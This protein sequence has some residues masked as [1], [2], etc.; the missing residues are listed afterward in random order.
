MDA[1][2]ADET[3]LWRTINTLV[4]V[5]F[6]AGLVIALYAG[7]NY[8]PGVSPVTDVQAQKWL[9]LRDVPRP[10]DW[11]PLVLPRRQC[12]VEWEPCYDYFRSEFQAV[13]GQMAVYV[14]RFVGTVR[15]ILNG[16]P[17]EDYGRLEQPVDIHFVPRM[18]RLPAPLLR[19]GSNQLDF[20]LT[21]EPRRFHL[22]GHFYIGLEEDLRGPFAV[23]DYLSNTLPML[24]IGIYLM[25]GLLSLIVFWLGGRDPIFGWFV[26]ITL[27]AGLRSY[28]FLWTDIESSVF[29]ELI[30]FAGSF[31]SLAVILAFSRQITGP[32]ADRRDWWLLAAVLLWAVAVYGSSVLDPKT[33]GQLG[34]QSLRI[35][36]ILFGAATMVQLYRYFR[37]GW[38]LVKM[39]SFVLFVTAFLFVLH[40]VAVTLSGNFLLAQLSNLSPLLVVLAF[41]LIA[42][43]RFSHALNRANSYNRELADEIDSARA[44]MA[45]AY[46]ELSAAKEEALILS[47]R[48]RIMREVHDGVGGKLAGMLYM[49]RRD[50]LSE[51]DFRE[52]ATHLEESLIDLR[53]IID[54]I[55]SD[56]VLNLG[57]TLRNF[58]SRV[59]P[60][61]EQHGI[62]VHIAAREADLNLDVSASWVLSVIRVLQEATS[63]V[64]RHADASRIAVTIEVDQGQLNLSIVDDGHGYAGAPTGRGIG[65]MTE[66]CREI[67]GN[68]RIQSNSAGTKVYASLPLQQ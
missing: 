61:L 17:I 3:V 36:A 4:S 53:A 35:S 43:Q 42:G 21:N 55:D 23:Q 14:P 28:Y 65:N 49:A 62:H 12:S 31:G 63:N 45:R 40:D 39:W 5:L 8:A 22:L 57:T 60:W 46:E 56:S 66:R 52:F 64:V 25:L 13:D 38:H 24:A 1:T 37:S 15:V 67:G 30:Y 34:N 32:V 20:V 6:A 11:T 44:S 26:L 59:Q 68:F 18:T 41:C 33:G 54:T 50:D 10:A 29:R 58:Q 16:T 19:P 7:L 47:E 9:T 27:F 48:H 2:V 51:N